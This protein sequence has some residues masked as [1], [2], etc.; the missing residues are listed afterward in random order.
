MTKPKIPSIADRLAKPHLVSTN[1]NAGA[2]GAF[3]PDPVVR[4]RIRANIDN[5]VPFNRN[6]RQSRNPLYDEIKESIR[7]KG[8]E[9]PPVVSR[10][11]PADPYMIKK[12]GN[13]RLAIL[14]E[15]WVETGDRRFYEFD[16]DFEPWTSDLD[17]L[18]SHM[19]ENEMKG[20]MLFIEKAIGAVEIKTELEAAEGIQI[21]T[22]QLS[23]RITGLGWSINDSNLGQMLYAHEH[24]FPVIPE[25][26]WS[27]IGRDTVKKIRKLLDTCRTF[28]ESVATPEEGSFDDV[29]KPVFRRLDG[30]A[31]DV[32]T[33]EFALSSEMSAKLDSPVLQV[34]TELQAIEE[35]LSKGGHRPKDLMKDFIRQQQERAA[36]QEAARKV[37]PPPPGPK[38]IPEPVQPPRDQEAMFREA[39]EVIQ[40]AGQ[41]TTQET[42]PVSQNPL[43]QFT[44][45]GDLSAFS[46][47]LDYEVASIQEVAYQAALDYA[48]TFGIAEYVEYIQETGWH[49]GYRMQL[50]IG[51]EKPEQMIHWALLWV[52]SNTLLEP[53]ALLAELKVVN[54]RVPYLGGDNLLVVITMAHGFKTDVIAKQIA[55][56]QSH[57]IRWQT[58]CELEAAMSMIVQ[59]YKDKKPLRNEGE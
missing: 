12:G 31:F 32:E 47:L 51:I 5:T 11:S 8:L 3:P 19:I 38:K 29:W 7:N 27:G 42:A 22:N 4:T 53:P 33:A 2:S 16:C 48:D 9:S 58:L 43:I 35:G 56:P 59:A 23:K 15:L 1:T 17:A 50:P 46:Y 54:K 6:P 55:D 25:S 34:R 41:S 44:A 26:F 49:L 37:P 36:Q 14:R 24:L 45:Y 21:S 13:T 57:P 18:V 20:G 40:E 28:W 52:Y 10:R 30:E 39:I